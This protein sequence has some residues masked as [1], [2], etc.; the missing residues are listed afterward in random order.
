MFSFLNKLSCKKNSCKKST[1]NFFLNYLRA[2]CHD[3][4]R[5]FAVYFLQKGILYN[6]TIKTRKETLTIMF[7]SDLMQ[8]FSNYTENIFYNKRNHT[9]LQTLF[10]KK[11]FYFYFPNFHSSRITL[12]ILDIL[13]STSPSLHLSSFRWDQ[14]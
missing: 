3:I 10:F 13:K 8:V 11:S 6:T 5:Y 4:P 1:K 7:I 12:I 2:S 14:A 9:L